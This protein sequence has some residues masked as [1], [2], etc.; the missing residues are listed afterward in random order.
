M[1]GG[2]I[3]ADALCKAFEFTNATLFRL[4]EPPVQ[5]LSTA[6]S[7]HHDK[8][9]GELVGS[10]QIRVSGSDAFN[11]LALLPVKLIRLADTEPGGSGWGH[12]AFGRGLWWEVTRGANLAKSR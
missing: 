2:V 8:S 4:D 10:I 6:L 12:S 1:H 5:V 7:Q 9:L 11:V 3:A